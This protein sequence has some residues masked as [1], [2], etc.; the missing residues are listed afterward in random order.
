MKRPFS[1]LLILMMAAL[2]LFQTGCDKENNDQP[3]PKPEP[4]RLDR[5]TV[6]SWLGR[7]SFYIT[8]AWR[9]SG[10]DSVDMFQEDTL[11]RL[12]TNAVFLNFYIS[13]G[14]G[15]I[16]F[17]G[18]GSPIPNTEMPGNALTF[19]LN[20]RIFLP[21]QM[22]LKWD[23]E[24]GTLGVETRGTTS[25]LPMMVP[26]KKGYLDPGS[27]NV[28]MSMEQAKASAVK[29]SMRFIYD[30]DDPKL[31]KVTYKITMKP[32]YQYYREPGQQTSAKF[33]VFQ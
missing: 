1:I 31:G 17:H 19:S 2:A 11:L 29:P 22:S 33:V 26:G 28:K 6:S 21:T 24:R 15:E 10:K 8:D 27:F 7:S 32:M 4:V 13:K 3:D 5:D 30:D 16:M 12:Y 14:N 23:E 20:I 25:Y 9:V 18:G